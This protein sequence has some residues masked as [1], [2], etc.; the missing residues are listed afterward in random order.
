MTNKTTLNKTTSLVIAS[1]LLAGI[2]APAMFNNAHAAV[3]GGEI[4]KATFLANTGATSATGP[5]PDL[6][7]VGTNIPTTLGSVTI[8]SIAPSS[9]LYVGA[10]NILTDLGFNK[11]WTSLIPGNS[12]AI[13]ASENLNATFASP[14]YSTGF[15]FVEPTC[16]RFATLC[17]GDQTDDIGVN[18]ASV[19]DSEFQVD[20]SLG[21]TPVGSFTFNATDDVLS[22]V[23]VASDEPFD[24]MIITENDGNL[25]I[26]GENEY[27][28]QFF[29]SDVLPQLF[30]VTKSWTHTD[31]NWDQVCDGA[32][33]NATGC[34]LDEM[35]QIDYRPANIN[36]T[37]YPEDDVLADPLDQDSNGN[38]TAFAQVKKEKFSNTNPGAF[39]ALTTVNVT[40]SLDSLTV[41]EIY[42]DCTENGQE[43]LQFVSKKPTRN[44][45]VAVANVTGFVTELTDAI[46][47][48]IGGNV[49]ASIDNA[50]VNITDAQY[51]EEGSTVFVLVKFQDSLK[52]EPASNNEFDEMCKNIESV[53]ARSSFISQTTDAEA[54]LRITNQFP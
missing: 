12:I 39:Y 26:H 31:Y 28:G 43:L 44:V 37:E 8:K 50:T 47:D 15:E 41:D 16:G 18:F 10:E 30:N 11:D 34:F 49:T 4:D 53:T 54:A 27:F 42:D 5:L 33:E 6:G 29:T 19:A 25:A 1:I 46:Y 45:K 9:D 52:G 7:N 13:S 48:G 21:L 40:S 17:T 20:L 32:I 23:G 38:Y 14:V 51:L 35:T 36:A 2:V 3:S 24:T 22:F